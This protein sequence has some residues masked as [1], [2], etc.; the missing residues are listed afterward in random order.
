MDHTMH[1]YKP[2]GKKTLLLFVLK[3]SALAYAFLIIL[4]LLFAFSKYIPYEYYNLAANITWTLLI[5]FVAVLF[6]TCWLGWL[7]YKHYGVFIEENSFRVTKGMFNEQEIGVSYRFV[8]EVQLERSISDQAFGVSNLTVLV[9][10][11]AQ[12]MPFS[13]ISKI[14]LPSIEQK[15][16]AEIQ[17]Y[18]LNRSGAM[19]SV[20][21]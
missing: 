12:G 6:M 19:K 13:E 8:Q 10:G 1:Q 17:N 18:I 16:A 4:I 11:E 14:D 5:V 15:K 2:L 20:V 3:R 9:L 7:E 21:K